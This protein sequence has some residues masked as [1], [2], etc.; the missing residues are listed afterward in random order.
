M[1]TTEKID[2][3]VGRVAALEAFMLTVAEAC[4]AASIRDLD[5]LSLA[6]SAIELA[7][8][9]RA[10]ELAQRMGTWPGAPAEGAAQ[11]AMV[12]AAHYTAELRARLQKRLLEHV[13]KL[14]ALESGA[15]N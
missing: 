11:V 8:I 4:L 13:E 12:Y 2:I 14:A 15:I 3:L 5:K 1:Q 10:E 9:H 7:M 6:M